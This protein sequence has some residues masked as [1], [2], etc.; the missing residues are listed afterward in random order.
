MGADNNKTQDQNYCD[1]SDFLRYIRSKF[2]FIKGETEVEKILRYIRK[3]LK[4]KQTER[5]L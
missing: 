4:D 5:F 3:F 2:G 1:I